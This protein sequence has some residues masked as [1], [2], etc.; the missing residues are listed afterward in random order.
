[1][2][3]QGPSSAV[4]VTGHRAAAEQQLAAAD[5][6]RAM[7]NDLYKAE[8]RDHDLIGQLRQ[9]IKYALAAASAHAQLA[10][11]DAIEHNWQPVTINVTSSLDQPDL[12]LS[13]RIVED[14]ERARRRS[15]AVSRAW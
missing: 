8:R 12:Q 10:T 3:S 2:G 13:E 11:L 6:F 7:L 5:E 9:G 1:M 15:G 4:G 14:L